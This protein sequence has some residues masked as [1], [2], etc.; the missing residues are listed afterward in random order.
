MVEDKEAPNWLSFL[1][2]CLQWWK[3]KKLQT[4]FIYNLQTSISIF[5]PIL[6]VLIQVLAEFG[7]WKPYLNLTKPIFEHSS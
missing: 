1:F 4:T 5:I 7:N 2:T 3:T 6:L